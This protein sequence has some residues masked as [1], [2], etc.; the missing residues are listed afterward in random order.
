MSKEQEAIE[1]EVVD[2][3]NIKNLKKD[4]NNNKFWAWV[5]LIASIIYGVTPFDMDFAPVIGWID[6]L[7]FFGAAATNF[8]QQYFFQTNETLN[9]VCKIAKWVLILFAVIIALM[10]LLIITLIIKR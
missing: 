4:Q 9:K 2:E 1:P 6:D 3:K 7:L 10:I 8:A 5:W